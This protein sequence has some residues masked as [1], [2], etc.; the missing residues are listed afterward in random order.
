[1]AEV[2]RKI[3]VPDIDA[4]IFILFPKEIL[5]TERKQNQVEENVL[6]LNFF[7]HEKFGENITCLFHISLW[8]LLF[9]WTETTF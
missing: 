3:S 4:D 5:L 6:C 7:N 9:F 8:D 2:S 1:M